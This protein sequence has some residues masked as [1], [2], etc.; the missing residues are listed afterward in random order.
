MSLS[1]AIVWMDTKEAHVLR[2]SLADAESEHIRSHSP[3][4]K[5]HH[6]AGEIGAGHVHLDHR[7]FDEIAES[8]HDVQEWLLVG[9][10][11]ARTEFASYI[12]RHLPDLNAKLL[13]VEPADHP[14]EGE[15]LDHARRAFKRIDRMQPNSPA[16]R[17]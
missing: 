5:V 6:K 7:Y 3:F 10:G 2:F 16:A 9:A 8:L 4:R 1:H 15:L 12:D 17:D 14:T 13:G 11:A